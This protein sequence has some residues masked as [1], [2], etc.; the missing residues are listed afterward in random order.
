MPK[1][2][3]NHE[4]TI[5]KRQDGRWVA[6]VVLPG[7]RRKSYYGKTRDHLGDSQQAI[8]LFGRCVE[9]VKTMPHYRQGHLHKWRKLAQEQLSRQPQPV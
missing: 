8:E 6:S 1:R 9:A 5:Y 3:A 7:G 4:G 2:R